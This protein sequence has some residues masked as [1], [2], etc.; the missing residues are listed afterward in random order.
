MMANATGK[1]VCGSALVTVAG[2]GR[3]VACF[4][5]TSICA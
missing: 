2:S 1:G 5:S 4:A 3:P